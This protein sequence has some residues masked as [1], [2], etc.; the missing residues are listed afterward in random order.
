MSKK[1]T[2]EFLLNQ[3]RKACELHG[4]SISSNEMGKLR[5]FPC[6]EQYRLKFGSF[7]KAMELIGLTPVWE[8]GL[9]ANK[10]K[11]KKR[12]VPLRMRFQVLLR[13]NF[14]CQYCGASPQDGVRLYMDHIIPYSKNGRTE[15]SNLITA[16]FE[17]NIGKRDT[18]LEK[19]I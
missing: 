9:V 11:Q 13:D 3:L 15:E 8:N 4:R 6:K 14:R 1:H 19:S 2:K 12:D 7:N 16:C 5:G 17:C 18:S 10:G